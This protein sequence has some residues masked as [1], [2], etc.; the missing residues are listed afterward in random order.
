MRFL[1]AVDIVLL[2]VTL[3]MV[4][5]SSAIVEA[6]IYSSKIQLGTGTAIVNE[7]VIMPLPPDDQCGHIIGRNSLVTACFTLAKAYWFG[8]FLLMVRTVSTIP[9][10]PY[11]ALV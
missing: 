5:A 6:S 7:N 8:P 11:S 10:Y 4:L 3:L 9:Y 2:I 1:Y